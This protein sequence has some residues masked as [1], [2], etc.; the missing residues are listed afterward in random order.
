M[1]PP[2]FASLLRES[3]GLDVAS[4]G[5]AAIERAVEERQ[6]ICGL[7]DTGAYWERA[8]GSEAELQELIE[9]VVVPETWFF[10]DPEAFALLARVAQEE[11]LPA[12]AEGVRRVLS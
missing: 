2:D 3:M 6:S 7:K 11:W 9:A 5:S 1:A 12:R 10:R 8:H 4:I